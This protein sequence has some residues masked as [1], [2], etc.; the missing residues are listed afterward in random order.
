MSGSKTLILAGVLL[1]AMVLV[2]LTINSRWEGVDTAVVNTRAEQMGGKATNP[3]INVTGDLQLFM[4]T[5]AGTIGGFIV[6]YSWRSLFA[7]AP[8]DPRVGQTPADRQRGT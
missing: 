7:V 8:K 2:S 1:A 4:F 3:L 5:V 6:G